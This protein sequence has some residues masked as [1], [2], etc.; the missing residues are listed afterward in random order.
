MAPDDGDLDRDRLV[1]AG[2]RPR[3]PGEPSSG[4]G[5]RGAGGVPAAGLAA[6]AAAGS[7]VRRRRSAAARRRSARSAARSS[8][9]RVGRAGPE[10]RERSRLRSCFGERTSPPEA[11][12][13]IS[14]GSLAFGSVSG[15]FGLRRGGRHLRIFRD[16]VASPSGSTFGR[17]CGGLLGGRLLRRSLLLGG[18]LGRGGLLHGSLLLGGRLFLLLLLFLGHQRASSLS[19]SMPRWRATVSRRATSRR[20][21][22]ERGRV[23]ELAG[24][25]AKAQVERLLARRLEALDELVVVE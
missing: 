1:P 19:R 9:E 18:F 17:L 24:G 20:A 5:S 3:C 16:F 21:I 2:R 7:P 10:A 8:A 22:A 4:P 15:G 12:G 6:L 14:A 11:S 13:H 25:V 23:L